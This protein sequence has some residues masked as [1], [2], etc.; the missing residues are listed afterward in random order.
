MKRIKMNQNRSQWIKAYQNKSNCNI[1]DEKDQNGSE[2]S[3]MEVTVNNSKERYANQMDKPDETISKR[4]K[5]YEK[6]E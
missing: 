3:K 5:I 4:I 2:R 1:M 6:I